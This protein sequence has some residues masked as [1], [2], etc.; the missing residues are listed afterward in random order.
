MTMVH[1]P[2][3]FVL[4]QPPSPSSHPPRR[5][6][7]TSTTAS[8]PRSQPTALLLSDRLMRPICPIRSAKYALN[9]QTASF[10]ADVANSWTHTPSSTHPHIVSPRDV[11]DIQTRASHA[12]TRAYLEQDHT[13]IPLTS[14]PSIQPCQH[15]LHTQTRSPLQ[16]Q[17]SRQIGAFGL[18]AMLK[19]VRMKV[20]LVGM[21]GV[22]IETVC[23]SRFIPIRLC[24]LASS[25]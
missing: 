11:Y 19:L 3:C 14:P 2:L 6:P 20:L 10:L 15:P 23:Q 9:A 18:E 21:R 7:V 1:Q 13:I 4:G 12:C 5:V 17:Y 24:L 8:A 16:D 25:V 22:G